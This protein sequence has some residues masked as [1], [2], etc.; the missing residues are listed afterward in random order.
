MPITKKSEATI[1]VRFVDIDPDSGKINQDEC[2]CLVQHP[3][4]GIWIMNALKSDN[5]FENRNFYVLDP[6]SGD[7]FR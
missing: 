6:K 7:I 3:D 1:E 5:P 4:D 2:I